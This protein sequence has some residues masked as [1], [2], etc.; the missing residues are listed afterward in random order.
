MILVR[1]GPECHVYQACDRWGQPAPTWY[2]TDYGLLPEEK[3][4]RVQDFQTYPAPDGVTYATMEEAMESPMGIECKRK[5][6]L[7]GNKTIWEMD[8]LAVG[9]DGNPVECQRG[10]WPRDSIAELVGGLF[11]KALGMPVPQAT[12]TFE[13]VRQFA[14]FGESRLVLW[15]DYDVEVRLPRARM[16]AAAYT[17]RGFR[18]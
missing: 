3:W 16:L 13:R 7:A 14:V 11:E 10:P 8:L 2:A 5:L 9:E 6:A 18:R 15:S 1:V 12:D 4:L 17:A